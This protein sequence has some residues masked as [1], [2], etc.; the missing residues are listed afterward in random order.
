MQIFVIQRNGPALLRNM[1]YSTIDMQNKNGRSI[2][3]EQKKNQTYLNTNTIFTNED[4]YKVDYFVAGA[5][6]K[7]NE[8]E[9]AKVKLY[10]IINLKIYSQELFFFLWACSHYRLKKD[11]N[12]ISNPKAHGIHNTTMIFRKIRAFTKAINSSYH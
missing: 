6:K 3:K 7:A 5:G 11:S 10:Y 2:N 9:N 8:K 12:H 1:K 4:K